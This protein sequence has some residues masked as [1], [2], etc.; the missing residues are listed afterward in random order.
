[1]IVLMLLIQ[2]HR[3]KIPHA[4]GV[5]TLEDIYSNPKCKIFPPINHLRFIWD[6]KF[7]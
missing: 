5:K 1:M 2:T 6:K 7:I 4:E 3:L